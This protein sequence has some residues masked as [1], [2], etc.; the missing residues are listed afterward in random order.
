MAKA[1]CAVLAGFTITGGY[2]SLLGSGTGNQTTYGAGILCYLASPT[3]TR[4]VLT[5]NT[6]HAAVQVGD[7]TLFCYGGGIACISS[8]AVVVRN[9]IEGNAAYGGGG[10][11]VSGN[12]PRIAD[13]LI[14]DNSATVGGGVVLFY[15][16]DLANNTI[17]RNSA[18]LGGGVYL[19]SYELSGFYY[20]VTSNIITHARSGGGV[21][22][23]SSAVGSRFAYNDVWNN[24]GGTDYSLPQ[25]EDFAGNISADPGFVNLAGDDFHLQAGSACINAGDPLFA[26]SPGEADVYGSPRMDRGRVDIGAAEFSGD[27][28][29]VADAGADQLMTVIPAAVTLDGGGSY[30]PDPSTILAYNWSQVSGMPVVLDVN[31]PIARFTPETYGVFVFEL[32]VTDGIMDSAPASVCVTLDNGHLPVAE[33]GLPVYTAGESVRL[34]GSGSGALHYHWRQ[35]SGPSVQISDA[36]VAS[37]TISGFVRTDALQT[38]VFQLTVDDGSSYG[39]ADTVEARIVPTTPGITINSESGVFD[40][41]KPSL[42]YFDGG[43]CVVSNG[44]SWNSSGWSQKANVFNINYQTGSR[45]A[46]GT[47]ERCGDAMILYLFRLA[48]NYRM[49]IQTIGWST[50]GQPAIDSGIQLNLTYRD[51]RYAVN[52]VTF[53]DGRCRDYKATITQYLASSV[54]G[55]QCWVDSYDSAPQSYFWPGILNA[56]VSNGNHGTPPSYYKAS[57]TNAGMNEYNGGLVGGAYWSVVGPGKNLQLAVAPDRKIYM[58]KGYDA[59]SPGYEYMKFYDEPNYPA[60]LPEPVTLL[61]P[62]DGGDPCGVVL[63]CKPSQNAVGYELLIGRDPY[64]VMD[65]NVVSDTPEPPTT[66]IRSLPFEQTWWTVRVRDACGSTIYADP[67][68][69]DA[70]QFSLPVQNMRTARRYSTVQSAIDDAAPA[71][72]IR[73]QPGTYHEKI[74]LSSSLHIRSLDLDDP[75]A[76]ARTIIDGG[77]AGVAVTGTGS[78]DSTFVLSGLTVTNGTNGVYCSGGSLTMVG[79]R[80]VGNALAGVKL[81]NECHLTAANCIIAGNKGAGVEMWMDRT[82]RT[83][84]YNYAA[85]ANC[86][87]AEN[88]GKGVWGGKPTLINSI[89][90]NNGGG[91]ASGD[92]VVVTYSDIQGGYSGPGNTNADP[93]FAQPGSWNGGVWTQGDYHLKS[94]GWRWNE[95]TGAWT[96]D[97]VTSPCIDAGAPSSSLANEPVTIPGAVEGTVVNTAVDMGVYGGTSQASVKRA[98]P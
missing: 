89:V 20:S 90:W 53:V 94:Q 70:F 29:P 66:V 6:G 54:D 30:D 77:G 31:G 81:W 42:F 15:G 65:F 34:N 7:A 47:Y 18:S 84:P 24:T 86:T 25:G 37:P 68:P 14:Y 23:A 35:I 2:G 92:A 5:G 3:I 91:G 45:T 10:V 40:A 87:I 58:F 79:C 93:C 74:S 80:V 22:L 63:T 75:S 59:V 85:I 36:S 46:G 98:L 83:I 69:I 78:A 55:E 96:A 60:R 19:A 57:L 17:T 50:G 13:N 73:L 9:V 97:D 28:R 82:G 41:N 76:T 88:Q 33:A 95:A 8:D 61:D 48:P 39:P 44:G 56:N 67:I 27:F 62:A 52:R 26:T 72:E 51:A 12:K 32:V 64:R 1:P 4:N 49:P 43:D 11:L 21:Y 38:C 16:G 71:D